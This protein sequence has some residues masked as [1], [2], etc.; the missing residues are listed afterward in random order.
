[1]DCSRT[2]PDPNQEATMPRPITLLLVSASLLGA[3]ALA[4]CGGNSSSS[5]AAVP[6]KTA[7]APAK[8]AAASATTAK[9]AGFAFAPKQLKVK[10]GQS[11]TWTN[12][13]SAAHTVSAQSG[14]GFDSGAIAQGASYTW[15]ATKPGTVSYICT[16][17][18]SMTGTI[19]VQ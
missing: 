17:H 11:I 18:P 12:E 9:I 3:T 10:V 2:E 7:A 6:A 4:A 19:T 5:T 14:A 13:D 16:I 1:M 15:K 8:T